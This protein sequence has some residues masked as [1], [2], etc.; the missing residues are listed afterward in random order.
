MVQS[1]L[2]GKV[3]RNQTGKTSWMIVDG[4]FNHERLTELFEALIKQP[5]HKVHLVLDN[6]GVHHCK[7]G[8]EWLT[9]LL[10]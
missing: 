8:N 7:P 5:G 4:N 10:E 2:L 1:F 6:L 9:V 3:N